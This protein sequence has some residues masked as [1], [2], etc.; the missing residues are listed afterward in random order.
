[1][2]TK[3][4]IA[5]KTIWGGK[6]LAKIDGDKIT[7]APNGD[8]S[9]AF[10]SDRIDYVTSTGQRY[11]AKF[12]NGQFLHGR[13]GDFSQAHH[14][15]HLDYQNWEGTSNFAT[16][17][18]SLFT[19]ASFDSGDSGSGDSGSYVINAKLKISEPILKVVETPLNRITGTVPLY[20]GKLPADPPQ[21]KSP[22]SIGSY[23]VIRGDQDDGIQPAPSAPTRSSSQLKRLFGSLFGSMSDVFLVEG[24]RKPED[25][26]EPS[27]PGKELS[28]AYENIHQS[29]AIYGSRGDDKIRG[30]YA[31]DHIEGGAGNDEIMGRGGGDII[32]GGAG[33]DDIILW[34]GGGRNT[35]TGGTGNDIF[36]LGT[37][38]SHR[39]T[40]FSAGDKIWLWS[41]VVAQIGVTSGARYTVSF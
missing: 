6:Y 15:K 35:I 13:N 3:T 10:T 26:A 21:E 5:Y 18:Q 23:R 11:V 30:S 14:S 29:H 1:M 7:H 12:E 33:N 8:W 38:G 32:L 22:I 17:D 39:I 4:E 41:G 40:D 16:L 31:H 25:I 19:F 20:K 37:K 9:K 2:I 34:G 24:W 27:I 36:R 28:P